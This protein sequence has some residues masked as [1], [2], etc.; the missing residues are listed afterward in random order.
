MTATAA[1]IP[2]CRNACGSLMRSGAR[3]ASPV[4]IA[5]PAAAATMRSDANHDALGPVPP[6]AEMETVT[7]AG[8]SRRSCSR[9]TAI[10]PDV[11]TTSAV[12][13]KADSSTLETRTDFLPLLYAQCAR[14]TFDSRLVPGEWPCVARAGTVVGFDGDHLGPQLGEHEASEVARFVGEID[15]PIWRQHA[16]PRFSPSTRRKH[17]ACGR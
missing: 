3:S 9:S 12:A 7:S 5:W 11:M 1:S 8:L 4:S 14:E 6:K 10:A 17:P 15:Y 16:Q 13:A 2:A